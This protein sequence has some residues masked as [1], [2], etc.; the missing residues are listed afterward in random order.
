M[1]VLNFVGDF[2]LTWMMLLGPEIALMNSNKYSL[3]LT[4]FKKFLNIHTKVAYGVGVKHKNYILAIKF[5]V[6]K[7]SILN[8]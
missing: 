3:Q 8:M 7:S 6:S 2:R 5:L 1:F 4:H